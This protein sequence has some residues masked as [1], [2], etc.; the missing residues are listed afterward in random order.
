[1]NVGQTTFD[2]NNGNYINLTNL[3]VTVVDI[4]TGT[5]LNTFP[6]TVNMKGIEH[7]YFLCNINSS[8]TFINNGN[9]NYSFTNTTSGNYNQSHWAF[10]DGTIDSTANTNHTFTNNG[11]YTVILTVKDSTLKGDSCIS[12]YLKTINVIGVTNPLQCNSGYVIYPDSITEDINVINSSTGT[13]L[14][15]LWD[16]GDGNTSILQNLSHTYNTAGPFYLCLI[17]DD[18]NGCSDMYCDS[19]SKNGVIFNKVSGFTINIISPNAT[20]INKNIDLNSEMN[21]YPN[22][23][24]N[25]LSIDTKQKISEISILNITGKTIIIT[26]GDTKNI[27]VAD[28]SNGIYFIKLITD[29]KTITKKFVKQ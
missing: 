1:L 4:Q 20:V 5:I 23:T 27:N 19:T 13:N 12:S 17:I 11:N 8:Y 22:P 10:G 26:R 3:G 2:P 9:G 6:N 28:L 15:Y 14:T 24:S 16:F 25:Q 7:K 29:E 18:G 21:I